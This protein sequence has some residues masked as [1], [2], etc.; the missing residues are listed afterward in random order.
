MNNIS[1]SGKKVPPEVVVKMLKKIVYSGNPQCSKFILS[2][3]PEIIED[4][5]AFECECAKI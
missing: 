4:A 5:N 2:S 1:S 3:F